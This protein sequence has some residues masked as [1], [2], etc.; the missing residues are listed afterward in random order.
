MEKMTRHPAGAMV[1]RGKVIEKQGRTWRVENHDRR[2]LISTMLTCIDF[3]QGEQRVDY[4]VG[5]EVY[6]FV[7]QDGTGAI[8]CKI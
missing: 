3:Y 8:L 2:G 4:N 6:F 5:D 7:F 1:E